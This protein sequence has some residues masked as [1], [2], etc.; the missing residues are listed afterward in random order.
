MIDSVVP[1]LADSA[2]V[3]STV[4]DS[5]SCSGSSA[6]QATSTESASATLNNFFIVRHPF[7]YLSFLIT[8]I[9][10]KKN[11][12]VKAI[13]QFNVSPTYFVVDAGMSRLSKLVDSARIN[14]FGVR[15]IRFLI[16]PIPYLSSGQMRIL[17]L[18]RNLDAL[19]ALQVLL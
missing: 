12:Q 17:Q 5:T 2:V 4:S 19:P 18:L 10:Q 1:V 14:V 3:S 6:L 13:L 7:V 11:R 8:F 15:P 9:I 16:V